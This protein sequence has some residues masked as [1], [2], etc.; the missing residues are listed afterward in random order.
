[1]ADSFKIID[2]STSL[3]FRSMVAGEVARKINGESLSI[4]IKRSES[5]LHSRMQIDT[6]KG[7]RIQTPSATSFLSQNNINITVVDT[8]VQ[9]YLFSF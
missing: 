8:K 6:L 4:K 1:M 3:L 2:N 5:T 7:G 9:F